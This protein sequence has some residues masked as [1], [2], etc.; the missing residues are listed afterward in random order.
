MALKSKTH[1]RDEATNQM[2]FGIALVWDQYF[3]DAIKVFRTVADSEESLAGAAWCNIGLTYLKMR[4]YK[5]AE[6]ALSKV[7][8][9]YPKSKL[10]QTIP[11]E[12]SG[13]IIAKAY[14]GRVHARL[15]QGNN[16]GAGKDL[17]AMETLR[18]SF[19]IDEQGHQISFRE[20][21]AVQF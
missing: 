21:A 17:E 9:S 10:N 14:L 2:A 15:G 7:I 8:K 12:E 20:L 6:R 18:S 11:H 4:L 19:V 1:S 13:L 5:D 3:L 16:S